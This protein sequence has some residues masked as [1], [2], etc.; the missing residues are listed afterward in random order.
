MQSPPTLVK[1]ILLTIGAFPTDWLEFNSETKPTIYS[2][3]QSSDEL[4]ALSLITNQ[5][6]SVWARGSRR[7]PVRRVGADNVGARGCTS[8]ASFQSDFRVYLVRT[9]PVSSHRAPA[10]RARVPAIPEFGH[11]K[12]VCAREVS[13]QCVSSA[14]KLSW[15]WQMRE[16]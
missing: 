4:L 6:W 8:S 5:S 13:R 3:H 11:R 12:E 9:S 2:N 1:S 14:Q 16:D 15:R 7:S 10:L